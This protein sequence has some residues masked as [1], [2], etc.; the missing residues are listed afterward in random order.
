VLNRAAGSQTVNLHA[1]AD[2]PKARSG[3]FAVLDTVRRLRAAAIGSFASLG[4]LDVFWG[5]GN[6]GTRYLVNGSGEVITMTTATGLDGPMSNP[7]IYLIGG[8]TADPLNSDHDEYD[9]AVIAHEWASFL[10]LTQ[11]RDNN[12]GGEHF[13]QE[14]LF[15]AAYSEGV[16]TP[17]G[18]A[19]LGT[20][21]YRDTVGYI[22]GS[23]SV[24]FEFDMESG[25]I[26][27]SGVGYGNEFE[28]SRATWDLID[29]GAGSPADGD[30]DPSNI[31]LA[32]FLTSFAALKTRGAP[33]EI[34]WMASLLQQLIDDTF[35]SQTDADTIMT[36]QG[37]QY[38]PA[39][40]ADPF[41]ALLTIGAGATAGALDAW[42]GTDPNP[43]LGPQANAVYRLELATPQAVVIDVT[44]TTAGYTSDS[45]RLDLS[46]H[47]LDRNI[48]G[49]D[50]GDLP[51]KSLS[52]NLA[53]GT[54]IIRVQ[55]LPASQ[56]DSM[57]VTFTVQAQ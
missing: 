39:G 40:G 8:S 35:L 52:L 53:A 33:Y 11:S 47:D 21:L 49:Q 10:Q 50:V 2:L 20:S 25:L 24:Q 16:V 18:L 19:L 14:L 42:S 34:A 57:P 13:G 37:A 45:H 6:I 23:T 51:D 48:V 41:P 43:I 26:P 4:P 32:D 46:I 56:A 9:E 12:F 28:I 29:G 54:Y 30:S 55:H 36:A 15:T 31:A 27:G 5:A 7:S 1:T 22:G 3:A 38:P 44:N 17:I